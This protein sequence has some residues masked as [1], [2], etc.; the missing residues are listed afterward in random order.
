MFVGMTSN[1][2]TSNT[3]RVTVD[4]GASGYAPYGTAYWLSNDLNLVTSVEEL[5]ANPYTPPV[6]RSEFCNYEPD[7]T[8]HNSNRSTINTRRAFTLRRG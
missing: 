8:K 2:A 6:P 4:S 1:I 5:D 3:A 7:P